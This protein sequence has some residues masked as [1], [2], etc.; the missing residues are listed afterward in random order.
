[1]TVGQNAEKYGLT[2]GN[3][4]FNSSVVKILWSL[5]DC[6]FK[7]GSFSFRAICI[8]F[9]T[10]D[11]YKQYWKSSHFYIEPH[12]YTNYR[13]ENGASF[14]PHTLVSWFLLTSSFFVGPPR[15]NHQIFSH[16]SL[17]FSYSVLPEDVPVDKETWQWQ[18]SG[19]LKRQSLV[20]PVIPSHPSHP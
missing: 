4:S 2:T 13:G 20:I 6:K 15:L 12:Q 7:S 9:I 11:T 8:K 14:P 1:M 3:N 19:H 18:V 10:N 17:D 16:H 5:K